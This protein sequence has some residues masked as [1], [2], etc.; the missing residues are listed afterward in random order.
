MFTYFFMIQEEA[1]PD[2]FLQFRYELELYLNKR[3]N[4]S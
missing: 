2:Q 3:I 4:E 1:N